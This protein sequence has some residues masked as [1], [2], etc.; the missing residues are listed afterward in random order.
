M[1][2]D[3]NLAV[4]SIDAL[5][6]TPETAITVEAEEALHVVDMVEGIPEGVLMATRVE[7]HLH[8]LDHER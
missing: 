4:D 8:G 3:H 7:V 5:D 2:A 1:P 6:I